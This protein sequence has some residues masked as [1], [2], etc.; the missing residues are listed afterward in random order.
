MSDVSLSSVL[1][2]LD[3]A[4]VATVFR[5][6]H[7]EQGGRTKRSERDGRTFLFV[8]EQGEDQPSEVVWVDVE[9]EFDER[10]VDVF[11]ERCESQGVTGTLLTTGDEDQAAETV[12]MAFATEDQLEEPEE[13]EADPRLL[14]DPAEVDVPI[15]LETVADLE[16]KIESAGLTEAVIDEYHEP[17][18]PTF[19][20]VLDEVDAEGSATAS[21]TQESSSGGFGLVAILVILVVLAAGFVLF[22]PF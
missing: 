3:A 4:E 13:D 11:A 16:A 15:T 5:T 22:G 18:Q 21:A 8:A 14:V 20:D 7:A 6:A 12:A 9:A 1:S 2:F 10:T 19:E 17:H